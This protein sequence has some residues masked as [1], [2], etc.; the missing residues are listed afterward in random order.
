MKKIFTLLFLLASFFSYSQSTTVVISQ[1]YGGGGSAQATYNSDYVELHN[2][3]A[4]AQNISGFKLAYGSSTGLLG[5]NSG[6]RYTFPV[7]TIIPA[8][9]YLLVAD[10][11]L[12]GGLA[13][14][15]VTKDLYFSFAMSRDKGKIVLGTSALVDSALLA[16]QPTGAVVDF[17]G[18]GTAQEFE[19]TGAAGAPSIT[20]A[21]FRNNNGCD[22]TNQNSS[23]FTIGAPNPRNSATPVFLCGSATN[24][25]LASTS[26]ASFGNV[27]ITNPTPA[28]GSFSISGTNLTAGNI[29]VGP[30]TGYTF[31]TA[32]AGPYTATVTVAQTGTLA[33]T[34]IYVYFTPT[35]AQSYNGNISVSGGG[36]NAINVAAV[37]TGVSNTTVTTGSA[38][39]VSTSGATLGGTLAQGCASASSYGIEYST[40]N[41]FT[42]GSGT[43]VA[44]TNLSGTSFSSSVTGLTP[45]TTYY[46]LAFA[47][48]SSGS[49]YGTQSSFTTPPQSGTTAEVVISQIYGGGGSGISG[50]A[51]PT[52]KAD[53]VELHNTSTT[54]QDIS[55]FK[56]LYGSRTGT[57]GSL[58]SNRFSFPA[59]TII[60]AGGYLLIANNPADTM[61]GAQL[62]VVAD[63]FF[64]FAMSKNNGKVALGTSAM[65]D[66]VDL[67]GQP[68]AAVIDFVGYGTA[69][70]FETAAAAG[71]DSLTAAYRNN[72]GCDDTDNN[73]ADFSNAAPLPRNSTSPVNICG[74]TTNPTIVAGNLAA[75]G[76]V[77]SNTTASG[78]FTISGSNLTSGDI[79]V[80]PLTGYTFS[81]SSTGLFTSTITVAQTGTLAS[82]TIYVNF[83]PIAV[84]SYN[85]SIAVSGGGANTV[86]VSASGAGVGET[87]IASSTASNITSN[88]ASVAGTLN[89]GCTNVTSYG[90]EYSTTSGFAAG[91]GTVVVSTNISGTAYSSSLTGLTAST[92][93]YYIAYAVTAT[94]TLYGTESSFTTSEIVVTP[95]LT[96]SALA[97]FGIICVGS[98]SSANTF[99]ISGS[100]LTAGNITVG[101]IDGYTF[102]TSTTGSYTATLTIPQTGGNLSATTV[103]VQF[104]PTEAI[105]YNGDIAITGGGATAT[106][107]VSGAGTTSTLTV[108]TLDSTAIT[109]NSAILHGSAVSDG[110]GGAVTEWGIEISSVQN[111]PVG[112]SLRIRATGN[113]SSY[114]VTATNL[115]QNT[116]YYYRAYGINGGNYVFGEQKLFS[117]KSISSGAPTMELM[118]R[119][120]PLQRGNTFHVS[121]SGLKQGQE[122]AV[123]LINSSGQL[124][125]QQFVNLQVDFL[126]QTFNVPSNI[127]PGF[128]ILQVAKPDFRTEKP[129]IV[130]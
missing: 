41:G 51:Q 89:I 12:T 18:Y 120:N 99:E 16:N 23:D 103:Y 130:H 63:H 78:S 30:L 111:F 54:S 74:A 15:P 101:P 27:C 5:A 10:S 8:G 44:S 119:P 69:E 84:Q 2:I 87:T 37:G 40:N 81:T 75:F 77:C 50:G 45:N 19:G 29:T 112:N 22:D 98:P 124:V 118:V 55:G 125:F 97:G 7:N 82:T 24:P 114:S 115:V 104:T 83:S 122:Y 60:P 70:E 39:G 4:V 110:C 96:A 33:S 11:G 90:I 47:I 32:L 28:S 53:Y 62:P 107:A 59:G 128:H 1:I 127:A 66:L 109:A 26:L 20:N 25:V 126:D 71:L 35:A 67:A 76:N 43:V 65:L 36:A 68:A 21:A 61:S 86:F 9:G 100:N 57:L 73:Q 105:D 13:N 121:L 17:I 108:S 6:N 56:L 102:S 38:T 94:G 14:L 95:T 3:S 93:Y 117:T 31:S 129:V 80:G 34:S 48:T 79:T 52:Y 91:T 92:T 85:G 113:Q 58:A 106:V 42:P 64:T 88:S 123:R 72:N 46:Y 49:I 116:T